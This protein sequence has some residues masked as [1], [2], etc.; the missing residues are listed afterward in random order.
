MVAGTDTIL[1]VAS[2][3]LRPI[4]PSADLAFYEVD[5][6]EIRPRA[7]RPQAGRLYCGRRSEPASRTTFF[8]ALRSPVAPCVQDAM[9]GVDAAGACRRAFEIRSAGDG[10]TAQDQSA[11]R[12]D[13]D[14]DRG[15][16]VLDNMRSFRCR[17]TTA[18]EGI[19]ASDRNRFV[20]TDKVVDQSEKRTRLAWKPARRA[21][22]R[23]GWQSA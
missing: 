3:F 22:R 4:L 2:A 1:P 5:R 18:K 8:A 20:R 21:E 10:R 12:A 6:E 7:A 11:S 14:S 15:L 23:S 13:V 19:P 16:P 17:Y 9:D